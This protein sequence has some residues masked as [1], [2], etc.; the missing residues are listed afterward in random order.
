MI[1]RPSLLDA[2]VEVDDNIDGTVQ[3]SQQEDTVGAH[4]RMGVTYA[5]KISA[6]IRTI[7]RSSG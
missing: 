6:A 3:E 4:R 5:T 1:R 7:T 2:G